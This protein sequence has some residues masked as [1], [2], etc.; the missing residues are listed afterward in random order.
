M[1]IRITHSAGKHCIAKIPP[2]FAL[3]LLILSAFLKTTTAHAA[4][5]GTYTVCNS[6]CDFSSPS[7]AI[8]NL[9]SQGVSGPVVFNVYAGTY[10]GSVSIGSISGAS[11]TNTITFNGAGASATILSSGSSYVMQMNSTQ[12]VTFQNMQFNFSSSG[13]C[14]YINSTSNCTFDNCRIISPVYASPSYLF[15]YNIE[16]FYMSNCTFS[17]CRMEGGYYGCL[18]EYGG[19]NKFTH[20]KFVN[21]YYAGFYSYNSGGTGQDQIT[22]NT[23]DSSAYA[24]GDYGL[25]SYYENGGTFTG[26]TLIGAGMEVVY[27]NNGSTSVLADYSNNIIIEPNYAYTYPFEI[28]TYNNNVRIAH[29]TVYL[30][31]NNSAYYGVYIYSAASGDVSVMDNIFD[32]EGSATSTGIYISGSASNYGKLDGN[33]YFTSSTPGVLSSV[34]VLGNPYTSYKALY[35]ALTAK[36][37]ETYSSNLKPTFVNL[38]KN[39]FHLNQSVPN[40]TGVDAGISKDIDGDSR[41]KLFPSA[42]ADESNYGKTSK[43]VA[44]F[45]GPTTIYSG[46]PTTFYNTA[47]VGMPQ[48][49]KW[50][51]NGTYVTDS[52]HLTTMLATYPSVTVKLEVTNCAGTVSTTSTFS[53]VYPSAAPVSD[54][55]SDKNTIQTN[56]VVRFTD[57]SSNGASSWQ[58]EITPD[59]TFS[60]GNK[61]PTYKYVYGSDVSQNPQVQFLFSGK[62]KVCLTANNVLSGGKL[63]KGNTLC[64]TDYIYVLPAIMLGNQASTNEPKGYLFDDGGPNGNYFGTSTSRNTVQGITIDACADST[65]LI[66]NSFSTACGYDYVKIYDGKDNTGTLLNGKCAGSSSTS[67]STGYA[68]LGPGYN[69]SLSGS[70]IYTCAPNT[71]I[72]G[73]QDTFKAGRQMYV[74]MDIYP[75]S[76]NG[77]GFSAY[78][79]TKPRKTPPPVAKFVTSQAAHNDSIC[80]GGVVNMINQSTGDELSYEWE[81]DND[82]TDGFEATTQNAA[83]LWLFPTTAPVYLVATNC[84]GTDT[85]SKNIYVF[86]PAAPVASFA[87]DNTTPTINDIVFFTAA[88]Q[89][90][91]DDY[92]WKITNANPPDTGR[93]LFTLGTTASSANP[94]VIF[95]DTGR[96]TVQLKEIN[97]SGSNTVIKTAYIHVKQGY[98]IPSVAVLNTGIGINEVQLNTMDNISKQGEND[99]TS[100]ANDPAITTTLEQGVTYPVTIRRQTPYYE[101]I[102]RAVYI[103]WNQDGVFDAGERVGVDS[104]DMGNAIW[105]TTVKVPLTAL[106]GATIMRVAANR[107]TYTNYICGQNQFGEYEDYRIH[108]TPDRTPPLLFLFGADTVKIEQGFP[109]TEPGDSAWD[110]LSGVITSSIKTSVKVVPGSGSFNFT[111]PLL[112]PGTYTLLYNVKDGAGN[113]AK[114]KQ[115]V[116]VVLGDTMRPDLEVAGP[117]TTFVL[118][119]KF[120][121]GLIDPPAVIRSEDLVDGTRMDTIIPAHIPV[122]KLDTVRVKY[123]TSDESYNEA[124]VYR[125]VI[126]Y[127]NIAPVMTLKG[128]QTEYVEVGTSYTDPLVSTSDNYYTPAE[129]DPLVKKTGG[130]DLTRLG[131]YTITYQLTDPSGNVATPLTRIINVVDTAAPTVTMNGARSDTIEVYS[132]YKDA[133]VASVDNYYTTLTTT[134]TGTYYSTFTD[135]RATRLG[136]YTIVYNVT[137]GSGN[138]TSMTRFVTVVDREAPVIALIGSP[139]ISICRWSDYKDSGYTVHDNYYATVKV[140][141]EG[142]FITKNGP[143]IQGLY[144]LRYKA[145]DGSGNVSYS[146]YRYIL[147][148]PAEDQLCKTGIKEGLSLDKYISVYPN[149][150]TGQLTISANLPTEERVMMTI[151]NA[152]GQQ[153]TAVSNGYLSQNSFIVDLS[154]QAAGVYMLNIISAHDKVTKQILLTK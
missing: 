88:A 4:M 47:K 103:D 86:A 134:K 115:R 90:C 48:T 102:T 144:S 111:G 15:C 7:D 36:G 50:Y 151:T 116:V 24:Y 125:Y 80:A 101:P 56:D 68:G 2:S 132:T 41:C 147:V 121:T 99:Y 137:D 83:W 87:A 67:T 78:W 123:H 5:A 29:N 51:V 42:G 130:L 13:E 98:C 37:F 54:F 135:G 94:A 124:N 84:G 110:N 120:S 141:E 62:Y 22:G 74:E 1:K 118:V 27:P 61:V 139:T 91:V 95:T 85:F 66:F 28:I 82:F 150:T 129:L 93:G 76:G 92:I 105:T 18:F 60:F 143:T 39:D 43:P 34:N 114:T 40:P 79:W 16:A 148:R 14:L 146:E 55:I 131:T 89:Q 126:V 72:A 58:W 25:L 26:N 149:P 69:G 52:I 133:G 73:K 64:K 106:T 108:I 46:A 53:V 3:V 81:L 142:T 127:D 145:T 31:P 117:D 9:N 10:S 63:G 77:Q 65:Y 23:F 107:G 122:N 96:Y 100:Y 97:S 32:I 19:Y 33:D 8:S 30:S 109:Y 154:S 38:A 138:K 153:I 35:A 21:Y 136:T 49:Y 11:S 6:G 44:K 57:L 20:N 45:Y 70:C 128:N 112:V 152:L 59:Y 104:N 113:A 75:F 119:N 71:G 140:E 12:W 17:N